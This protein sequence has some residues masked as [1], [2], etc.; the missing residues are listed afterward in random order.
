MEET[1]IGNALGKVVEVNLKA[2]SL[3]QAHFLRVRVELPLEKPLRRGGIIAS[4]KGDKV[5]I[6]FKYER[7]VWLCFKCGRIGHEARE[8]SFHIDHQHEYPYGEWLK[9]GFHKTTTS[10]NSG[11]KYEMRD[12]NTQVGPSRREMSMPFARE[13]DNVEFDSMEGALGQ[14]HREVIMPSVRENINVEFDSTQRVLG[15]NHHAIVSGGSVDGPTKGGEVA[16]SVVK[17]G[18]DATVDRK[19]PPNFEAIITELDQSIQSEPI[20][21]NSN[22]IREQQLMDNSDFYSGLVDIEVMDDDANI[23]KCDLSGKQVVSCDALS[24]Q[25]DICE[26]NTSK[27]NTNLI[28]G[29]PKK[30]GVN[31]KSESPTLQS[32]PITRSDVVIAK[33]PTSMAKNSGSIELTRTKKGTWKRASIK[34]WPSLNLPLNK[35]LG[36]KRSGKEFSHK[37]EKANLTKKKTKISNNKVFYVFSKDQSTSAEVAMQP[38]RTL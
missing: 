8:C 18:I 26:V 5:C 31:I 22:S 9:A 12:F 4:P 6:G 35:M 24:L 14:N 25:G 7:L 28:G 30:I 17:A 37:V 10:V 32:P 38:H 29:R 33:K 34:S 21:L 13:T 2:F 19:L 23:R 36:A 3:D 20:N 15:Q 16:E 27:G 11:G 1:L